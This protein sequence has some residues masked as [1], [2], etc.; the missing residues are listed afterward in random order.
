M[1]MRW[2]W[3]PQNSR[4]SRS[5]ASAGRPTWS[6][7]SVTRFLAAGRRSMP[8]TPKRLGED[9]ADRQA[10]FSEVYGSWKTTWMSPAQRPP[11]L[12]AERG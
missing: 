3:P 4:G 7:S 1:A 10:G 5:T 2:R 9:V 11:V 8:C 6:S 12:A